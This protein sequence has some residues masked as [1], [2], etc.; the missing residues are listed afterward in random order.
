MILTDTYGHILKFSGRYL[1]FCLIYKDLF[2]LGDHGHV[3][4][5]LGEVRLDQVRVSFLGGQKGCL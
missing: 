3:K 4:S 2:K 1:H 5:W